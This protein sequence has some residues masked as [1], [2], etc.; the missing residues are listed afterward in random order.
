MKHLERQ[1][2]TNQIVKEWRLWIQARKAG[3]TGDIMWSDKD[4]KRIKAATKQTDGG[5]RTIRMG[6]YIWEA[7]EEGT[8]ALSGEA[9]ENNERRT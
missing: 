7:E 4:G 3:Y 8:D 5:P 2:A 9:S 1:M 6:P